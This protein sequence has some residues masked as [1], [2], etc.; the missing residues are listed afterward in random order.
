MLAVVQI[1]INLFCQKE[2]Y[3]LFL[4]ARSSPPSTGAR[5]KRLA[6]RLH[7]CSNLAARDLEKMCRRTGVWAQLLSHYLNKLRRHASRA[8]GQLA[9]TCRRRHHKV[10]L[11]LLLAFANL[12][13][14]CINKFSAVVAH[15]TDATRGLKKAFKWGNPQ[16]LAFA[17]ITTAFTSAPALH[18]LDP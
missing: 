5:A 10:E 14:R 12:Y 18:L 9:Q 11:Q 8:S 1:R 4:L 6:V 13:R 7:F 3:H 16:N 17:A 15:L 2:E